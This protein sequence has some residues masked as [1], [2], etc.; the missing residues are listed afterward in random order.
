MLYDCYVKVGL[1]IVS[2]EFLKLTEP[3]LSCRPHAR[4]CRAVLGMSA[5]G[6]VVGWFNGSEMKCRV[7][8]RLYF[9][10]CGVVFIIVLS[11]SVVLEGRSF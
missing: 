9:S 8:H 11:L 4:A 7:T 6:E 10:T 3:G 5:K 1:K 2:K